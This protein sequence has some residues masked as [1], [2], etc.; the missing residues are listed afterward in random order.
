MIIPGRLPPVR[1]VSGITTGRPRCRF[2]SAG[3]LLALAI[4]LAACVGVPPADPTLNRPANGAFDDW[5]AAL[6]HWE[7]AERS[8]N[9]LAQR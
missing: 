4:S 3:G 1:R 9:A 5:D 2:N 7:R 8:Q 6:G